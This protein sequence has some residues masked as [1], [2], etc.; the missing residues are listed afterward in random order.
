MR[1]KSRLSG[2]MATVGQ[3]HVAAVI[4]VGLLTWA[5]SALLLDAW[6]R[7]RPRSS[8]SRASSLV[9]SIAIISLST[10]YSINAAWIQP[11]RPWTDITRRPHS[12]RWM[13]RSSRGGMAWWLGQG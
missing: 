11:P 2:Q 1:R 5:G 12:G 7:R 13:P 9:S 6:L 4:V 8:L 10:A 3:V